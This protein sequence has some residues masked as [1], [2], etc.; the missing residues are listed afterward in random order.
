MFFPQMSFISCHL[1]ASTSLLSLL[2]RHLSCCVCVLCVCVVCL[3]SEQVL[4]WREA[5]MLRRRRQMG[6]ITLPQ[7]V[8]LCAWNDIKCTPDV[9]NSVPESG[10]IFPWFT[11]AGWALEFF[12]SSSH[13]K[14]SKKDQGTRSPNTVR[15]PSWQNDEQRWTQCQ[16][17][18]YILECGW[19]EGLG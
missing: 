7:V 12:F 5:R 19:A 13:S 8:E 9:L 1:F 11:S 4:Q 3:Q 6:K 16:Y 10:I 15:W 18:D 2:Q 14:K 17:E